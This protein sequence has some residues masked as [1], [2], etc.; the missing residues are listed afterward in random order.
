M[1]RKEEKSLPISSSLAYIFVEK[2]GID[3]SRNCR[4]NFVLT[5]PL[6]LCYEQF[7]ICLIVPSMKTLTNVKKTLYLIISFQL[8]K[9]T[10]HFCKIDLNIRIF[11]NFNSSESLIEMAKIFDAH[12][13]NYNCNSCSTNF[14]FNQAYFPLRLTWALHYCRA[15]EESISDHC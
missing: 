9:K 7:A 14:N 13:M 5:F 11:I 4:T 2:N 15:T 10:R 12:S 1:P 8:R 6:T 3:G